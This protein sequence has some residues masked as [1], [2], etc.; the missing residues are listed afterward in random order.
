[1]RDLQNNVKASRAISPVVVSD[2]TAQVSQIIDTRGFDSL[3]FVIATGTLAD[4]DA[5][6]AVT[7]DEGD[8]SN[9]SDAASVPAASLLG[10]LS[11]ASFTFADDNIVKKIGYIGSKRYVRLT[12][13]PSNNASS[14]PISV[15]AIQGHA[16]NRPVA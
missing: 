14:A 5:T 12:V 3:E 2:N 7:M 13:T 10:T 11:S 1:M 8:Q 16:G 9:L 15:V 4:V 6:F